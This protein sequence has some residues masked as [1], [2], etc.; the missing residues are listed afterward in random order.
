MNVT[1]RGGKQSII[2]GVISNKCKG[3]NLSI[4]WEI[5]ADIRLRGTMT[6]KTN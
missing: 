4:I 5:M 1:N 6:K 3:W 2:W